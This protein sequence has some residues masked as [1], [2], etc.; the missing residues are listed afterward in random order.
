[1]FNPTN[2]D[3]VCV[4]ATHLEARGKMY[5]NKVRRSHSIVMKKERNLKESRRKM[6]LLR[7]KG[8]DPCERIVPR[9][10]MMKHIVGSFI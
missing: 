9:K 3:E 6:L 2:L 1:M 4:Q 8:R 5:K 7:K 10:D